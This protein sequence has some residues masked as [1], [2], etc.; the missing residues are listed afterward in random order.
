MNQYLS[1]RIIYIQITIFQA[2]C[3]NLEDLMTLGLR[4]HVVATIGQTCSQ[5]FHC[6]LGIFLVPH[7]SW[8]THPRQLLCLPTSYWQLETLQ[9][10]LKSWNYF[11]RCVFW[12]K[13]GKNLFWSRDEEQ[14]TLTRLPQK[15]GKSALTSG[16]PDLYQFSWEKMKDLNFSPPTKE[17]ELFGW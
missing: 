8:K 4:S 13:R 12:G 1:I 16:H 10:G 5:R 14:I 2:S 15:D 9:T 11:E 6:T 3:W 7:C 17:N